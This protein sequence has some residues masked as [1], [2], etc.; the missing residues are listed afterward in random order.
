MF[1]K[2]KDNLNKKSANADSEATNNEEEI[3]NPFANNESDVANNE[4]NEETQT[5]EQLENNIQ[6]E[7]E[8]LKNQYLRLAADFDNY[9]KRNAQERES[10]L[11]YGAEDTL[12]KLLPVIDT[13]ERAYKSISEIDDPEKLKENFNIIQ[14]QFMDSL[15]KAGLQKIEAVGKE[16]DPTYH[17]AVMQTPN[18]D[19]PDHTII[20]ELQTGY[21]LED[22]IIRP[23]LVNVAVNQ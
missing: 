4:L 19:M 9:R 3:K 17:E 11:K 7:M 16:F 5:E 8:I 12:K 13:F 22:R 23:A 15:E 18:N 20:A 1:D 2:N 21:K 6:A 10:L 14:K